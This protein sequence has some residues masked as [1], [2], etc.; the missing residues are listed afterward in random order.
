MYRRQLDEFVELT[1]VHY[2][3]NSLPLASHITNADR[4][5]APVDA[6]T[7]HFQASY[8]EQFLPA[9]SVNRGE[10]QG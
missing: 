2:K 10:K 9:M 3:P 6:V 8:G 7:S 4:S 5:R 1:F